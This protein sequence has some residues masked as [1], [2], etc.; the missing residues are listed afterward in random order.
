MKYVECPAADFPDGYAIS[1]NV[2]A[3]FLMAD[4]DLK[5]VRHQ[6]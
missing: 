1:G 3:P 4:F 5:L 2:D 6:D